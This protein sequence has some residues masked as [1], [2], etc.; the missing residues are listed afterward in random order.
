[1]VHRSFANSLVINRFLRYA[2]S[3]SL[4]KAF[5]HFLGGGGWGEDNIVVLYS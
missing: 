1:M 3:L 5:T 2:H 4:R